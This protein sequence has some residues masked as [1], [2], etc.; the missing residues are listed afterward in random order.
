MNHSIA[1]Q[2]AK[3]LELHNKI[4]VSAQ[5]VQTNLWDMCNGLKDMRDGKLYKELGY[6]N[7]EEYC[8]NECGFSRQ[9][10]HKYISII[11]N[12]KLENVNPGLH[13]GVR[14]L[15]LLS[16]LSE[17]DQQKITA[18]NDVESMTVKELE[19]EIKEL[20]DEKKQLE[21]DH[22]FKN[23]EIRSLESRLTDTGNAMR[24]AAQEKLKLQDRVDELENEI[25]ELRSRPID[26]A[27]AEPSEDVRQLKDTIKNLERTTDAELDRL[28]REH[29]ADIREL[30]EEN[31]KE[32]ARQLDEQRREYERRLAEAEQNTDTADE[33]QVFKAYYTTAYDAFNRMVEFV[34]KSE[35]KDFF[36]AKIK[37]LIDAFISTNSIL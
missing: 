11:E 5:L 10:A 12:V 33:K 21:A 27:V 4:M 35:D 22:E 26:V 32:T 2:H 9:Q 28:Q 30:H 24:S 16:T 1:A 17:A 13:F 25:D 29:E 14:K 23:A 31:R 37:N 6:Q 20:K 18:E 8:E 15:Y 19:K 34:K 36:Q 7:F 3:A